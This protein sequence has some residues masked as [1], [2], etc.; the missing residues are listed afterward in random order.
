MR[1]RGNVG[2]MQRLVWVAMLG[3]CSTPSLAQ[4]AHDS[5]ASTNRCTSGDV[6]RRSDL[7]TDAYEV[8]GCGSDVIYACGNN[9][10]T[11]ING[12]VQIVLSCVA[13]DWCTQ[14]GCM[15]DD[16]KAA[17][18]QFAIDNSCPSER[19]TAQRIPNP[20]RPPHDIAA[21]PPR[22]AMWEQQQHE[23]THHVRFVAVRGC[24]VDAIYQCL[25]Q[26]LAQPTCGRWSASTP[27]GSDPSAAGA[28]G[29]A[30]TAGSDT[31]Q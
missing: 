28:A 7:A 20:A 11:D 3:A 18:A 25:N 14:P 15:T 27:A 2:G 19:V 10:S 13:T 26:K 1:G 5:F 31:P 16:P 23:H 30:T 22:L 12:D 6:E 24:N 29:S 4:M 21:D 17:S 9:P 8:I